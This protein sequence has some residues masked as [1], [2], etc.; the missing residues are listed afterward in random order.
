MCERARKEQRM[1]TP[2]EV[3]RRF[4]KFSVAGIFF[5]GGAAAI[6]TGAIVAPLVHGLTGGSAVAVGAAA[7][8]APAGGRL[9]QLVVGYVAQG[10]S[11]RMPVDVTGALGRA[12][13]LAPFAGC[14]GL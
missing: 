2:D 7:T 14:P 12:R 9:P 11:R 4:W 3:A 10:R 1:R 8:L 6:D 5:Q 13:G